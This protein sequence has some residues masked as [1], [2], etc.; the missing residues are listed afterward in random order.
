MQIVIVAVIEC[1]L[2]AGNAR[3]RLR[4]MM[5][6]E[7]AFMRLMVVLRMMIR[8]IGCIAESI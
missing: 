5:S 4:A 7:L 6:A 2:F 8:A 1:I 3:I